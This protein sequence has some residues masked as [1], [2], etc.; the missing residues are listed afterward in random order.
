MFT[1]FAKHRLA[2]EKDATKENRLP[3]YNTRSFS[4]LVL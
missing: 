3:S 1:S 2:G 4:I